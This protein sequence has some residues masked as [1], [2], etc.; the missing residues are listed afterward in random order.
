[1]ASSE[2]RPER[3]IALQKPKDLLLG[4]SE[5][6]AVA[7]CTHRCD[8]GVGHTW[9]LL[10]MCAIFKDRMHRNVPDVCRH[11]FSGL[12]VRLGKHAS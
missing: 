3:G 1:M 10:A 4:A 8:S 5:D 7:R 12:P 11:P 9:P 2:S 6:H